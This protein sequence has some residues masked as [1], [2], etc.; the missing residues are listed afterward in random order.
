M[1]FG[2]AAVADLLEGCPDPPVSAAPPAAAPPAAADRPIPDDGGPQVLGAVAR[3][4]R[5]P[6]LL[7]PV[8]LPVVA[9]AGAVAGAP[10]CAGVHGV[11]QW[12][13][14][15]AGGGIAL[16]RGPLYGVM[17]RPGSRER[18]WGSSC[19]CRRGAPRCRM[20]RMLDSGNL[21]RGVPPTCRCC[22]PSRPSLRCLLGTVPGGWLV[23]SGAGWPGP[24]G[25]SVRSGPP[26]PPS[27]VAAWVGDSP[28]LDLRQSP[29]YLFLPN[30]PCL[31]T[32]PLLVLSFV[33][34]L[35]PVYYAGSGGYRSRQTLCAR[36][37]GRFLLRLRHAS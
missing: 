14:A 17:N 9:P 20:C 24:L 18:S 26:P 6:L 33:S 36:G 1:G 27:G 35:S 30:P 32:V 28:D 7:A 5:N 11:Q 34:F 29:A 8:A 23:S 4:A 21:G 16:V 13:V 19:S 10:H 25:Q 3:V 15:A 2:F 37:G 31:G 12:P 22:T